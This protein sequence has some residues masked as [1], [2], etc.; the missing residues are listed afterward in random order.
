M[1][2]VSSRID[3]G[4]SQRSGSCVPRD[5]VFQRIT[6]GMP[7]S[8]SASRPAPMASFVAR[9]SAAT[10]SGGIPN[11]SARSSAAPR[12]ASLMTSLCR[13]MACIDPEPSSPLT[14]RTMCLSTIARRKRAGIRSMHCSPRRMRPTLPSSNSGP[15]P[16]RP[17]A[18]PVMTTVSS[19]RFA[20]ET[21]TA[22]SPAAYSPASAWSKASE[23][24]SLGWLVASDTTSSPSASSTKPC[25]ARLGPTST[26]TRTPFW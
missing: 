2:A 8:R 4:K 25:S 9:S 17:S 19:T 18:A 20:S 21:E 23:S 6:S 5:V 16:G 22:P 14:T 10:R 1:I 24:S 3:S 7:A 26:K 15:P 11:C 13:S 12:A